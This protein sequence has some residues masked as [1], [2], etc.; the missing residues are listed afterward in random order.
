MIPEIDLGKPFDERYVIANKTAQFC[1]WGKFNQNK[2][3]WDI[4]EIKPRENHI[5]YIQLIS[6]D[7]AFANQNTPKPEIKP[8]THL[9]RLRTVQ[10]YTV[11]N[12]N[13]ILKGND[14]YVSNP[15]MNINSTLIEIDD[16]N[17]YLL[18]SNMISLIDYN[19][20]CSKNIKAIIDIKRS[21]CS[22]KSSEWLFNVNVR[23][24]YNPN[25]IKIDNMN[26]T[27]KETNEY[28]LYRKYINSDKIDNIKGNCDVLRSIDHFI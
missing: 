27:L 1:I 15:I 17:A 14:K 20:N 26:L 8:Q 3:N 11:S 5:L 16:Y 7:R 18:N 4:L 2:N 13:Y 23:L 21:E 25:E 6:I 22:C 9:V 12:D 24:I 28:T 19:C 10:N